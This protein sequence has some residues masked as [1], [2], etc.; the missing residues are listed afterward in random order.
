MALL[1]MGTSHNR[2]YVERKFI[3]LCGPQMEPNLA[4]RLAIEFRTADSE[5]CHAIEHLEGSINASRE[6]LHPI[7]VKTLDE[8]CHEI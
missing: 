8:I 4:K 1:E 6:A 7:L 3:Q 2:W 5:I